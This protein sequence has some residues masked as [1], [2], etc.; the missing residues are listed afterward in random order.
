LTGGPSIRFNESPVT[1]RAFALIL[2]A[3]CAAGDDRGPDPD[4]LPLRA[5]GGRLAA[6]GDVLERAFR[7]PSPGVYYVWVRAASECVGAL[8]YALDGRQPLRGPRA[9]IRLPGVR[10]PAWTSETSDAKFKAEVHVSRPGTYRLSLK[11]RGAPVQVEEVAVTLY[12]SAKPLGADLDH[13]GDPGGGRAVFEPW[14]KDVGGFR[15]DRPAPAVRAQR[16]YYVDAERGDDGADGT[17]PARAWKTFARLKGHVFDPGDAILLR[18]GGRW[19]GGFSAFGSGTPFQGITLGAYG[20]GPRPWIDGGAQ[21]AVRLRDQ[22]YWTIQDLELTTDSR[23]KACGLDVLASEGKPQPR[24]IRVYNVVSYDNGGSGIH[25]G[26]E[27]KEGNGYDGVWVENCLSFANGGDG[28]VVNGNDQTGCRNS[29]IRGCTAYSN[30]G[31][32]GLWIQSGQNGLIEDCRAY[33]NACVNIWTWNSINVTIR[34]CEAFRGRPPRDAGGFDIDWGCQACTIEYCYSRHNEGPGYLI[35]GSGDKA[36]R[37]FPMNSRYNLLRYCVSVEDG[38]PIL[39]EETFEHGK[40]YHN[41]AVARGRGRTAMKLDGWPPHPESGFDGGWPADNEIVNNVLVARDGA[42]CLWVD[43]HATRQRNRFDYN[44]YDHS[45]A[46]P[47]VRWGGRENGPKFWEKSKEGTFPPEDFATFDAFR[48][49]TGQEPHGTAGAA[50]GAPP[51]GEVRLDAEW[52]AGRARFLTDTGAE[53][54]GIPMAPAD[55]ARTL[56]GR[57]AGR[58]PG[59]W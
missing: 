51:G 41:L 29:V 9:E 37:G 2:L 25:V 23:R 27:F 44:R 50:E 5:P 55:P 1:T 57:P 58:I 43:D 19:T 8:E 47:V 28:I 56:S 7:L 52:L 45:G 3:G 49:A 32:A 54:Y 35:M 14:A 21:P 18:R 34:R 48:A 31:M 12:Y 30:A 40:V 38:A 33:N 10:T 15:P 16:S 36:Y 26:S 13:S 17:S 42:A 20:E 4:R 6:D 11:A 46:G 22:S 24:G 39:M 53:A 59:P